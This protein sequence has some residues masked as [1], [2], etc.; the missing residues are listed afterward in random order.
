HKD[1]NTTRKHY[2]AQTD[3]R[4]RSAANAVSLRSK[5]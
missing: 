4:R 3:S 2:A 5:S 1:V